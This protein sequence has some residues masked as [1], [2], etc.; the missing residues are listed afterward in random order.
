M[1]NALD[2]HTLAQYKI[3]MINLD[4]ALRQ[5]MRHWITGVTVVTSQHQDVRHGMTVNSFTSVSLDPPII[6][7]TLANDTRTHALVMKS[8][9]LA[10]TLLSQEQKEV[11]DRFAGRVPDH[12]DRFAGLVT[13]TLITGAPLLTDGL[14]FVDGRI[15]QTHT[16]PKSTLF[17][18]E[19]LAAQAAPGRQP[20][21]YFNRDYHR[22]SYEP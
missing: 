3:S 20:L 4:E 12:G 13:F 16:L 1:T 5:V 8:G 9:I 15:L 18:V 21:V 22:L 10:V 19:V 7:V 17:L 6:T 11:S 2:V 14:G